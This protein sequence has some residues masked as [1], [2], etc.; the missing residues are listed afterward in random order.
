MTFS[1]ASDHT[2]LLSCF[3]EPRTKRSCISESFLRRN[4]TSESFSR[5]NLIPDSVLRF[6]EK[7]RPYHDRFCPVWVAAAIV[8]CEMVSDIT[9]VA[10][11]E[12]ADSGLMPN[13]PETLSP[14]ETRAPEVHVL[15]VD[16]SVLDR[17]VIERLLKTMA[18][19]VTS[20]DSGRRAL[21]MLGVGEALESAGV[22]VSPDCC[23]PSADLSVFNQSY[24]F[25]MIITDYCMPGMTGFDLLKTIKGTSALKEIPV[26]IMSSENVPNRINR[27]LAE[28]AEE[29]LLKPVQLADVKRLRGHVR[30][31]RMVDQPEMTCS[32]RKVASEGAQMQSSERR[33]RLNGVTVP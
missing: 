18:Y 24:Q 9:V 1:L 17:K 29:F 13:L 30:E 11:L 3:P 5:S 14:S 12:S 16:D 19:K 4:R 22:S 33:P 28:G 7:I 25:S 8:F 23:S 27:C 20:V 31:P 6:A 32:K 15:A 2:I 10:N 26:V 21:E